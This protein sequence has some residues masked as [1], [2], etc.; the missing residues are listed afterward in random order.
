MYQFLY[1]LLKSVH[2]GVCVTQE[3]EPVASNLRQLLRSFP[4]LINAHH[5]N[6]RTHSYDLLLAMIMANGGYFDK[7][8]QDKSGSVKALVGPPLRP[9]TS[10]AEQHRAKRVQRLETIL[11]E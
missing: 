3:M 6:I 8:L 2:F 1:P 10:D 4:H 11:E 9:G 7:L 5:N